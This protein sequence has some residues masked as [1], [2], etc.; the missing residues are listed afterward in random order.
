MLPSTRQSTFGMPI[1]RMAGLS[2]SMAPA[3]MKL[4]SRRWLTKK[5]R[6]QSRIDVSGTSKPYLPPTP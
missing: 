2:G 6:S 5:S 4:R 1:R 3:A